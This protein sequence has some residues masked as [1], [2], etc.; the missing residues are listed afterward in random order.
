MWELNLEEGWRKGRNGVNGMCVSRPLLKRHQDKVA[1][2]DA[3]D[4]AW[5]GTMRRNSGSHE[6]RKNTGLWKD[7]VKKE[8]FLNPKYKLVPH[9][10]GI[11]INRA[12]NRGWEL[13]SNL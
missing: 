7:S 9:N 13:P 5:S 3:C 4:R 10:V 6:D 8:A 2:E 1:R 11:C 12:G